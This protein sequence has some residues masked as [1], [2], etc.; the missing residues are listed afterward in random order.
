MSAAIRTPQQVVQDISRLMAL[1][2]DPTVIA[3]DQ[4]DTL[5]AQTST[6]LL[7]QHQGLEDGQAKVLGP[8]ADGLLKLR[9]ITRR[10]LVVVS[11]LPDTWVLMTR[12]APTP[13]ADRFRT[14][15]LPDRIPTAG[16]RAGDR[17]EAPHR[18]VRGN[19]LR[20]TAPHLA[21]RPRR[22]RRR[23]HPDATRPAAPGGPPHRLVP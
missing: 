13:V 18:R 22:L 23:A 8:I 2:L 17:G 1:T 16:D 19:V 14:S 15:T 4:L 7:N 6:S 21:D 20:A 3:V 12:A 9:D 5:F 10:T 11:C